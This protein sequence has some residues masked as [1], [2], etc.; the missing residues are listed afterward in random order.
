M[1][2][3]YSLWAFFV[4]LPLLGLSAAWAQDS[5]PQQ[6]G[7]GMPDSTPQ[8]PAPAYGPDNSVPSIAENPP[9]SGL[10]M[11]N[12]EPH[13][14]PLSYLQAGAHVSESVSS[15]LE[16]TLGGSDVS[17]ISNGLGSLELQR[18]WSNY[19][20]ALDYLG[21]VGYYNV[22]GI[23]LKQIQELGVN[24]K[25]T[26][27]RGQ[28][29]VRD[30]FSYQPEGTFGGSYGSIATIGAAVGGQSGFF[31]GTGLGAL[32]QVPRLMNLSVAD[33][34]ENLTPR[35]SITA[36]GGYG[37]VHFMGNEPGTGTSFIGNGQVTGQV[38]YDRVLGPHDQGALV[39]LYQGFNFSTGVSFH[40]NVVQVMWG[41][42][43]SGRMDFLIGA[44][45]QFTQINN[46][47]TPSNSTSATIPPCQ[48]AG[49]ATNPVLECP[50]NDFRIGA[51]GQASLRYRFPKISLDL[52]YSHF[53]TSGSGFFAGAESDI[54]RLTATRPLGR[55]WTAFSDIGY[56]RNSRVTPLAVSQAAACNQQ[57]VV[58]GPACPGVSANTYQYGF[59]GLGLRRNFGRTLKAYAS[60]QFNE[61]SFDSSY[62][63]SAGACNRI[64]QR[65]VGTIGLDW[66]P[67]PI[68][69]D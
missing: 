1:S 18:L 57:L 63:G 28:L 42:R 40:S 15:N 69:L 14:A 43:I 26:W 23:G 19:D 32:G 55:I 53:L 36:A 41:H 54:A 16:N 11:P 7:G 60:Y 44:G 20:L 30:A 10:D 58:G 13:A 4:W 17:T 66:T 21:G 38:A 24:Q 8:Q 39:Y 50:S 31:G 45:P 56:S 62:C 27:K 47:F 59:A 46:V 68:R 35:S 9:I 49:T 29:S 2:N 3:R 48:L 25:I 33:V 51:A 67:R 22:S 61:L 6:P 64:S 34:V 65:H 5:S 37:F 12:L 52:T